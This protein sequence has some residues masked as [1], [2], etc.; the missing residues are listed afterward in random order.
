MSYI[1]NRM[2]SITVYKLIYSQQK[3]CCSG[4]GPLPYCPRK[5]LLIDLLNITITIIIKYIVHQFSNLHFLMYY[6]YGMFSS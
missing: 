6:K 3:Q 4:Y 1:F 5:L 2:M